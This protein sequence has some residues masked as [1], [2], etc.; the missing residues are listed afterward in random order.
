MVQML[1]ENRFVSDHYVQFK[2]HCQNGT[3]LEPIKTL[4]QKYEQDS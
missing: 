1:G 3:L 4:L 2:W